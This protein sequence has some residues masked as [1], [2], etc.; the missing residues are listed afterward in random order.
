M[1]SY[2]VASITGGRILWGG[3]TNSLKNVESDTNKILY[4]TL[5][6]FLQWNGTYFLN[7]PHRYHAYHNGSFTDSK[8]SC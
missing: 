6:N 1:I 3:Y 2:K 5:I 8:N 4:E 7:K